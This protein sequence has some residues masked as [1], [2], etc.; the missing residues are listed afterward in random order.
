[1]V[2]QVIHSSCVRAR[3]PRWSHAAWHYKIVRGGGREKNPRIMLCSSPTIYSTPPPFPSSNSESEWRT[4]YTVSE[5]FE[6]SFVIMLIFEISFVTIPRRMCFYNGGIYTKEM[7]RS[8]RGNVQN[9]KEC[10]ISAYSVQYDRHKAIW[11]M[12]LIVAAEIYLKFR[13][14]TV[15]DSSKMKGTYLNGI[16]DMQK[17]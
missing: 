17:R 7:I 10:S 15:K 9:C 16:N 12:N 5:I 3:I 8:Y 1:M 13:R 6:I 4:V 2:D 14:Q 11:Y